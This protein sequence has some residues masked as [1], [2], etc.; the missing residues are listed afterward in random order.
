MG[1][2]QGCSPGARV[3]TRRALH[4]PLHQATTPSSS[5]KPPA[6][7]HSDMAALAQLPLSPRSAAAARPCGASENVSAHWFLQCH[8]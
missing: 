3:A 7:A 8:H 4:Q 2:V 6:L 5:Q 1:Q